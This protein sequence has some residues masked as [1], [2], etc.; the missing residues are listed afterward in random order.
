MPWAAWGVVDGTKIKMWALT[1]CICILQEKQSKVESAKCSTEKGPEEPDR[2]QHSCLLLGIREES[3]KNFYSIRKK[4]NQENN[5]LKRPWSDDFGLLMHWGKALGNHGW[6][7]RCVGVDKASY[8]PILSY[9]SYIMALENWNTSF[10][11][12]P[13]RTEEEKDRKIL[14]PVWHRLDYFL[15]VPWAGKK[16]QSE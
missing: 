14:V 1:W 3:G 7:Q 6:G 9:F 11:S 2:R 16:S 15:H 8:S 5:W 10:P 12:F 13:C 4:G